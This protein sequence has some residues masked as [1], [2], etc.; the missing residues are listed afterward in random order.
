MKTLKSPQTVQGH[1]PARRAGDPAKRVERRTL[2]TREDDLLQGAGDGGAEE[3]VHA[4][5]ESEGEA[6]EQPDENL[7][8]PGSEPDQ[9]QASGG[10][11]LAEPHQP[12]TTSPATTKSTL[13]LLH[14][15]KTRL[16]RASTT[17]KAGAITVHRR[18]RVRSNSAG[19]RQPHQVA[20][21]A[22]TTLATA[23][24]RIGSR[25]KL[26]DDALSSV[27]GTPE[28]RWMTTTITRYTTKATRPS[29]GRGEHAWRHALRRD[30]MS[31]LAPAVRRSGGLSP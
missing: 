15:V 9:E 24:D 23:I 19:C 28:V 11:L 2:G 16:D 26:A 29:K 7:S 30:P 27:Y 18:A 25:Q 1:R 12:P 5:H 31:T 17:T 21:A 4:V 6:G 20:R 14:L 13:M 10:E 22:T 8:E 3:D